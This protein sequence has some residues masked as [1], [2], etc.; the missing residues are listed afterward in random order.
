MN[1]DKMPVTE[2]SGFLGAG[3]AALLNH[4]FHNRQGMKI[5][6]IVNDPQGTVGVSVH[7]TG[8]MAYGKWFALH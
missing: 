8:N 4:N 1:Q 5:G 3:K 2:L 7:D 6:V